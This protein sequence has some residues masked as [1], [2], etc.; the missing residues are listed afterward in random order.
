LA[1]A[2]QQL[3]KAENH[4]AIPLYKACLAQASPADVDKIAREFMPEA[5]ANP[6][7]ENR[8]WFA[9]A[10]AFCGKKDMA[11]QLVKS[12]IAGH[13]CLPYTDMQASSL[14]ATMRGSPDFN[15]L[16]AE[17]KQCR[18]N[19]ASETGQSAH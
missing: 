6:D 1:Q 4:H 16:L 15:E 10:Y 2:K 7:A 3:E 9:N 8:Y 14:F 17:A 19:F 12:S 13:Y 11:V 18:G 5:L